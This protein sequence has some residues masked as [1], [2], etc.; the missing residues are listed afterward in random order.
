L[1]K[2]AAFT[3]VVS[4]YA[5]PAG[6]V[7]G[8]VSY[9]AKH[10][11]SPVNFII[12]LHGYGGNG[13]W[14]IAT[15]RRMFPDALIAAPTMGRKC[16]RHTSEQIVEWLGKVERRFAKAFPGRMISSTNLMAL[17]RG[18]LPAMAL[19]NETNYPFGHLSMIS[20]F[21]VKVI[22]KS[23]TNSLTVAMICGEL[24]ARCDSREGENYVKKLVRK[25]FR[26]R[27][28]TLNGA[29][30]FI[31]LSHTRRIARLLKKLD[32]YT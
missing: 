14:N 26:A 11:Q 3:D 12:F 7:G 19:L 2:D 32:E 30:H 18:I 9:P 20:T 10:D 24:D 28:S 16:S 6:S 13:A 23:R 15:V 31:F 17:S 25:G 4:E 5:R 21:P 1:T 8:F 29:N 27:F 22:T